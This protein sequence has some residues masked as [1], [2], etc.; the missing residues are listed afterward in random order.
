MSATVKSTESLRGAGL[1]GNPG[2]G[3]SSGTPSNSHSIRASN[4]STGN[5]NTN[6]QNANANNNSEAT[7]LA[8]L[9]ERARVLAEDAGINGNPA[10]DLAPLD[11][12]A[13][14]TPLYQCQAQIEE[15]MQYLIQRYA[16]VDSKN[17]S[18]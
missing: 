8:A 10:I 11:P 13:V 3:S 6:S 1:E 15:A 16:D 18:K 4:I 2:S 7:V 12:V 9:A 5:S 14:L 17:P